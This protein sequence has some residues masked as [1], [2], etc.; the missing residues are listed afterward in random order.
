MKLLFILFA[1]VL[2]TLQVQAEQPQIEQQSQSIQQ[3]FQMQIQDEQQPTVQQFQQIAGQQEQ[4]Q[5]IQD[6]TYFVLPQLADGLQDVGWQQPE[7]QVEQLSQGFYLQPH[8]INDY[9]QGCAVP[10]PLQKQQQEQLQNRLFNQVF[11]E[12]QDQQFGIPQCPS[13]YAQIFQIRTGS[14]YN[15]YQGDVQPIYHE[16]EAFDLA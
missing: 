10:M 12:P 3:D 13:E 4:S 1:F 2:A 16:H 8:L 15:T 14:S 11:Y 9:Q 6:G 7:L 5:F